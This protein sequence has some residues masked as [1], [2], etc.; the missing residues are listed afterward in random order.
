MQLNTL[1]PAL[2]SVKDRK[3]VG[4]GQGSGKGGT[5]TR[6]HKGAQSR[7][8]YKSK[9]GFEGGQLPLQ[10]RLPRYGFK[11]PTRVAYK[12]INLEVL[13]R[14]IEKEKL[15][16]ID[17]SMLV[18]YGLISKHDQY[19]ILGNGVLKEKIDVC[20]HAFSASARAV[21]EKLGGQA[22]TINIHA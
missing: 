7:S 4:R 11:N 16:F 6:G 15:A 9:R 8:G 22:T 1:K 13:Q 10:R 2:G 19:K 14:L 21:I 12:P 20:A 3:R 18:K 5:A 17:A